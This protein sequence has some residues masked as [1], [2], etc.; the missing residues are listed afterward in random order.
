MPKIPQASRQVMPSG[1]VGAVRLPYDIARTESIGQGV[2]DLGNAVTEVSY[3]I[4]KAE[5][6]MELS[7]LDR[8]SKDIW[9]NAYDQMA[10]TQDKDARNAIYQQAKKDM[11]SLTSKRKP[12]NDA[13]KMQ[14]NNDIPQYDVHYAQLDRTLRIADAKSQF[15]LNS[16]YYAQNGDVAGYVKQVELANENGLLVPSEYK[17][18]KDNA[19]SI[20]AAAYAPRVESQIKAEYQTVID[21]GGT[22]ADAYKVI[23]AYAAQGKITPEQREKLGNNLDNFVEGRNADYRQ[24]IVDTY[25]DFADKLAAG[26]FTGDDIALSK[27]NEK[28]KEEFKTILANSRKEAPQ[29]ASYAGNKRLIDVITSYSKERVGKGEALQEIMNLRYSEQTITDNDY[30]FALEKIKNP[31]PKHVAET[32]NGVVKASENVLYHKGIGIF[33]NDWLDD[34]EEQSLALK[35]TAFLSWINAESQDGKYP[36]GKAMY[37][38]MRELGVTIETP[39]VLPKQKRIIP[40]RTESNYITTDEDYDKLAAGTEFYDGVTGVWRVKP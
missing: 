22:K 28:Q 13:F 24:N 40:K 15:E 7:T 11:A 10:T 33:G 25:A 34:A 30:K 27:L 4:Q 12:V 5:D 1:E 2:A 23:D 14:L 26:Q 39:K 31:Y 18:I 16:D 17:F 29:K 9:N 3:R 36:D 37:E 19:E 35:N 20:V 32:I 21:K 38:K 6:A 8:K